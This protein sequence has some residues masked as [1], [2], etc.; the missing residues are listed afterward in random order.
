MEVVEISTSG[1]RIQD[2]ALSR[3]GGRDFFTKDIEDALLDERI[4]LAVHSFKDLA[5]DNPPGL[6]IGAVLERADPRDALVAPPGTDL[7]SLPPGSVVGTSSLRRKAFL[8]AAR[9]DVGTRELRGN[10]PT[11]LRRFQDGDY[12]A[13]LLAAAGLERLG[14]AAHIARRLDPD[15]MTPAP[16]QGAVAVQIRDSDPVT[17]RWV[18]ALDHSATAVATRAERILL[19]V[20]EGGCQV[21]VGALARLE[22]QELHLRARVADLDGSVSLFVEMRG[23]ADDPEAL[24]RDAAEAL[25]ARGAAEIL[26]RIREATA[27]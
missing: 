12:D 10:V 1:D 11:R 17:R 6:T 23:P 19:S 22:G 26:E 7:S 4:D 24:G 21:P 13:L 2:V 9:S 3:V 18:G 16:A 5:T 14:L 27:G 20:L 25:L 15:V 8:A